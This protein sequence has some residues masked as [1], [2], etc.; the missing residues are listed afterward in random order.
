M[1]TLGSIWPNF[2][3][4]YV[5]R[6][7]SLRLPSARFGRQVQCPALRK[8]EPFP[9]LWWAGVLPQG[10]GRQPV[11]RGSTQSACLPPA[12]PAGQVWWRQFRQKSCQRLL[13]KATVSSCNSTFHS[14]LC[15]PWLPR[16]PKA[17][18]CVQL[19]SGRKTMARHCLRMQSGNNEEGAAWDVSWALKIGAT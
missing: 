1:F 4:L 9:C 15:L 7:I 3:F 5:K 2:P 12:C 11:L 19:E 10:W 14:V 17:L 8:L 13:L 16:I 18:G 6:M